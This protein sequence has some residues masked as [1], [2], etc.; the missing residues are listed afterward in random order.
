MQEWIAQQ[1]Q[2][3]YSVPRKLSVQWV[4]EGCILPL[5]DSLD[6]M[7]GSA[8]LACITAINTYHREPH[9]APPLAVCCRTSEHQAATVDCRLA[10]QGAVVVQPLTRG[11]VDAYLVQAGKPLA[12]LRRA[13]KKNE[14]LRDLATTPL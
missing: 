14:A 9:F 2:E 1:L 6:E 12:A 4:K 3:V 11:D 10:L 13:L 8:H 7:E 5:L